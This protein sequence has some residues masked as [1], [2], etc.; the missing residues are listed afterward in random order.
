MNIWDKWIQENH[1]VESFLV[2]MRIVRERCRQARENQPPVILITIDGML[3]GFAEMGV[4]G[5]PKKRQYQVP[6]PGCQ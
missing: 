2:S 4:P 5:T 6:Y 1:K 3:Q